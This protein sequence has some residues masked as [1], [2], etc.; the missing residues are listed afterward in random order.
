MQTAVE[1]MQTAV[2]PI[3]PTHLVRNRHPPSYLRDYATIATTVQLN[4]VPVQAPFKP[5][6]LKTALRDDRWI[7]AMKDE[8]QA[9]HDNETWEL[10]S[11]PT[12][13]NIVGSKWVYRIKYKEDGTVDRYKARLV[14]KGF[15]QVSGVDYDET[16]SPVVKQTTI[17][18][19]IA[20]FLS[21]TWNLRQL[22]VKN[23]FL[24]GTL[25]ETVYM[26]QPPGFVAEH[27]PNDVCLLKKSL[28][29][30]K[31]APRAWFD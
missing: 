4:H 6:T 7:N 28:Y 16:F 21:F 23:A 15:M 14:A 27:R 17:R 26:E 8:I 5:K 13:I 19:V 20:L 30:L 3:Q 29:G 11:R 1:P 10:V 24:Y 25:K 31:Q 12:D 18:L 22:D 9:L 2:E